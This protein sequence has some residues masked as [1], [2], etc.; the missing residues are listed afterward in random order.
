MV[1]END[2]KHHETPHQQIRDCLHHTCVV[3][4]CIIYYIILLYNVTA[5]YLQHKDVMSLD[6][7]RKFTIAFHHFSWNMAD[8]AVV[9]STAK[10]SPSIPT[11]PSVKSWAPCLGTPKGR[12]GHCWDGGF[13][14][15]IQRHPGIGMIGQRF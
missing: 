2:G 10:E 14:A 4:E 8:M 13:K 3:L 9:P 6:A 12:H 1:A 5:H 7:V 15:L 11:F